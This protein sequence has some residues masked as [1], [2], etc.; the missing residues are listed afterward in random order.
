MADPSNLPTGN[1]PSGG[2]TYKTPSWRPTP[3]QNQLY[4]PTD[5]SNWS[6]SALPS[7]LRQSGYNPMIPNAGS[8]WLQSQS[9]LMRWNTMAAF[10]NNP[11]GNGELGNAADI[12]DYFGLNQ[13]NL[14]NPVGGGPARQG[15]SNPDV[16][17]GVMDPTSAWNNLK[18]VMYGQNGNVDLSPAAAAQ[19]PQ[20]AALRHMLINSPSDLTQFV[21]SAL[22][23][24]LGGGMQSALAQL[25]STWVQQAAINPQVQAAGGNGTFAA[26]ANMLA[27]RPMTG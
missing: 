5:A 18:G 10:A 11:G 14:N 1:P 21:T 26:I 20:M 25:I 7:L 22:G 15:L 9:P 8:S 17:A 3:T 27:G 2:P 24:G 23:N 6:S 12:G 16:L 19:N 13:F 4:D